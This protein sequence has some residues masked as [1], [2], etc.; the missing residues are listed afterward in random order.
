M[1][2]VRLFR[3]PL[4]KESVIGNV[5][6]RKGK[7]AEPALLKRRV[8]VYIRIMNLRVEFLY[9]YIISTFLPSG[10]HLGSSQ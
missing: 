9:L 7:D 10:W 1:S 5:G 3:D 6:S 2:H 8:C 4:E